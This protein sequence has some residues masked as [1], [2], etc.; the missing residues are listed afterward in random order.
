M[1]PF[2]IPFVVLP[3]FHFIES[4]PC[5][6]HAEIDCNTQ[7]NEPTQR[8]IH[9]FYLLSFPCDYS[10]AHIY[11]FV[12]RDLRFSALLSKKYFLAIASIFR[13]LS[14]SSVVIIV[15]LRLLSAYDKYLASSVGVIF[16]FLLF[17]LSVCIISKKRSIVNRQNIQR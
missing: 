10:I 3:F 8:T 2:V 13:N 15:R 4:A 14:Y 12:K 5:K 17:F 11:L 1:L 6:T 16:S 7:Q 9:I